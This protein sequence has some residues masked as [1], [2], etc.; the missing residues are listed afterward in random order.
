MAAKKPENMSFEESLSELEQLVKELEQGELPLEQA[1]K[2]FERGIALAN[3]GQ[4][5][6][7]NAE[8]QIKILRENTPEAP[9]DQLSQGDVL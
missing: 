3:A 7:S 2:H 8:Q 6:L 5:K 1:M 9:L 4:Q